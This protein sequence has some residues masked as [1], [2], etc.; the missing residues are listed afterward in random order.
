MSFLDKDDYIGKILNEVKLL[1]SQF[2]SLL[3]E[4][5]AK[6]LANKFPSINLFKL[7]HMRGYND[8]Y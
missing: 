1:A 3:Q 2:A 6:I 7:W 5:I 4:E 8:M